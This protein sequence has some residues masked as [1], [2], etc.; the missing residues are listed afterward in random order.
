MFSASTA[1]S[2]YGFF[3]S[4]VGVLDESCK[5]V[6]GGGL[7]FK[8]AACFCLCSS[9]SRREASI[10]A[11]KSASSSSSFAG[12]GAGAE[13]GLAGS[14]A[15]PVC[16]TNPVGPLPSA[17]SRLICNARRRSSSK[18]VSALAPRGSIALDFVMELFLNAERSERPA[19]TY[20]FEVSLA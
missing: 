6:D 19:G 15:L 14:G 3:G 7:L 17:S 13:T 16:G 2:S 11:F 9:M 1:L 5:L 18:L 4:G 20:D 10:A 8:A 12:P